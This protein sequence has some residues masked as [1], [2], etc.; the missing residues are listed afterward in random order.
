MN[1]HKFIGIK[2]NYSIIFLLKKF[3]IIH[4]NEFLIAF[5]GT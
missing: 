4:E 3:K 2:K 1:I 5:Q